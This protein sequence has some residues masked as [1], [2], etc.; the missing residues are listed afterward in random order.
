MRKTEIT[1]EIEI[2]NEEG[3]FNI[4]KASETKL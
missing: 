1:L 3:V 2:K 4:L